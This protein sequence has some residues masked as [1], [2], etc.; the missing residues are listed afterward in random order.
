MDSLP[1]K[2]ETSDQQF[3]FTLTL[4]DQ[5]GVLVSVIQ[6]FD[7]H[8]LEISSLVVEPSGLTPESQ[9]TVHVSGHRHIMSEA[10]KQLAELVDVIE[11]HLG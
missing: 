7:R 10:V 2:P 8:E 3:V 4:R 5:P 1:N 11:V 9:M 6:V